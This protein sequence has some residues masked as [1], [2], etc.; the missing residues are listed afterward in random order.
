MEAKGVAMSVTNNSGA[1]GGYAVPKQIEAAIEKVAL[2]YSPVRQVANV[3]QAT[4]TDYH[5]L[6]ATNR[7]A[8]GWVNELAARGTTASP[9]FKDVQFPL[10][11]LYSNVQITQTLLDNVGFDIESWIAQEIGECF[12]QAEGSTFLGGAGTSQPWGILAVPNAAT[13]DSAGTRAFGTLEYIPT[14]FA[15]AFPTT[16]P[17]DLLLKVIFSVRAAYR[18]DANFMMNPLTVQAIRQFKD[19]YGRYIWEPSAQAGRPSMLFGYPVIEAEDMPPIAANSMGIIFGNFKRGYEIVDRYGI[20]MLR[21]PFS[22]K[23]YVGFYATKNTSG[24]V[25]NS[26]AL[27]LVKFSVT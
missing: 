25:I 4:T 5:K 15:G 6:V 17:A 16:N 27:K 24:N 2:S 13:P 3:V 26:E 7:A 19:A 9:S 21:D 14:G 22:N 11:V 10:G 12:G 23:P 20:R 18:L 1:E 8:T